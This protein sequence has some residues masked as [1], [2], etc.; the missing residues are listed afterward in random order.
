MNDRKGL[1]RVSRVR[2]ETAM[3]APP[4]I[5][6]PSQ[7]EVVDEEAAPEVP[8]GGNPAPRRKFGSFFGS[9]SGPAPD[10]SRVES[11]TSIERIRGMVLRGSMGPRMVNITLFLLMSVLGIV[12]VAKMMSPA[13]LEGGMQ[14]STTVVKDVLNKP[15][16]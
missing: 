13:A 9:K 2:L 11:T 16:S 5:A 10:S 1:D 3:A 14:E 8:A 12:L 4:E 6:P 7:D 15:P